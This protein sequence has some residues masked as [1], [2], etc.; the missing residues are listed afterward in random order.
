MLK[1][2]IV[3]SLSFMFLL[4]CGFSP[5][6]SQKSSYK[7]NISINTLE[8][9]GDKMIN[10]YLKV[11]LSKYQNTNNENKINVKVSSNYSKET[12]SKDKTAKVNNYKLS[13]ITSFKIFKD[14][15]IVKEIVV[16]EENI[17]QNMSDKFEEQKYEND[18]KQNFASSIS[19]K[20]IAELN[21][22]NDN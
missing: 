14:D 12:I 15:K 9:N 22:F 3:Y 8:F 6:Y 2:I 21:L 17:M 10:K 4:Q 20:F 19:L 5:I 16:K 7:N 13:N 1:K 11:N 18:I